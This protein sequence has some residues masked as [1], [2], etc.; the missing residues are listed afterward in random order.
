MVQVLALL[1]RVLGSLTTVIAYVQQILGFASTAAQ[2]HAPYELETIAANA[3]N[4][5]NSPTFGNAALHTQLSALQTAVAAL[6]PT[7]T[8]ITLPP[9]P[10]TGYGADPT[11]VAAYVW[12]Y[13]LA[14]SGQDRKS[15]V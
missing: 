13:S 3:A 1:V 6:T 14:G 15:V 2:E 7:G 4:T 12:A 5:V 11:G 10:P 9:V 8:P